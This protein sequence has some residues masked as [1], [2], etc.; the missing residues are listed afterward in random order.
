M[1]FRIVKKSTMDLFIFK[2]FE[3]NSRMDLKYHIK[4]FIKVKNVETWAF[5][6]N[7][8]NKIQF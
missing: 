2:F 8:K 4:C 1:V 5:M 6:Y 3:N 7:G